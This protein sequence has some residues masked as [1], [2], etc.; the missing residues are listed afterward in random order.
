MK[1]RCSVHGKRIYGRVYHWG[2]RPMCLRCYRHFC[3]N[4]RL[5][6]NTGSKKRR[7]WLPSWLFG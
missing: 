4:V 5:V 3:K 6:R 1:P 2:G 7:R